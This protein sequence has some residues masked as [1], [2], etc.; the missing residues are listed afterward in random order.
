MTEAKALGA[1]EP[2]WLGARET[3]TG[4]RVYMTAA[5]VLG[6]TAHVLPQLHASLLCDLWSVTRLL[7]ASVSPSAKDGMSRSYLTDGP[8]ERDRRSHSA[9]KGGVLSPRRASARQRGLGQPSRHGAME[10][11]GGVARMGLGGAVRRVL[12]CI[13]R[14]KK[15]IDRQGPGPLRCGPVEDV[16]PLS[17][18]S[19][20]TQ[21]G[22]FHGLAVRK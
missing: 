2:A 14:Q 15:R 22:I 10:M 7:C 6:R 13:E 12:S 1:D 5:P 3:F 19:P 17:L 18:S 9:R 11:R 8:D 16:G 21:C 4:G 20:S